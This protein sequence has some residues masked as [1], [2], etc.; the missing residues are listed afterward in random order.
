MT[1][2]IWLYRLYDVAEEISL[3]LVEKILAESKPTAR[4]RLSRIRPKSI[5]IP[6]PPVTVEL[7]DDTV[8]IQGNSFP[9][10]FLAKVYDLGVLSIIMRIFLPPL[11][12]Y[13]KIRGLAVYLTD[14]DELEPFFHKKRDE[15]REVLA[16]TM[17]KPGG[18]A[19]E[20]DYIIYYFSS[21]NK[22]WDPV[23]LLLGEDEP[24][25]QQI[26][27]ETLQHTFAYGENDLAI[28]T[29]S[30]ALIYDRTISYDIPDLLEFALTQLLELR[31]YDSVLSEEMAK[32]YGAIEEA[33]AVTHFRRL[34]Q[35]REIM[36]KLMELVVEINEIT[37]KIQNSL[38]VTEDV[39]YARIY[40][41]ALSIFRTK[42]W[43]ESIQQKSSVILQNYSFLSNRLVNQQSMLLETAIV[44][45]F[46]LEILL[47]LPS[48]FS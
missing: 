43:L 25:S 20:E 34:K 28:I 13:E 42:A 37:E 8:A 41:T 12:P 38:K 10:K 14:T 23:P 19:F 1:N 29:W 46:L 21:W 22:E 4:L 7:G 44:L 31:Y 47:T 32:M 39:Y 40:G 45:L 5:H 2:S 24:V 17:I 15:V 48:F 9:V 16:R 18:P 26:R 30:S 33:E 3:P 35:Y 36:N 27:R 6:N 11:Y